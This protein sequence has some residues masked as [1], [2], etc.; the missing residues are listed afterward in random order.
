MGGV[1]R[2]GR[3]TRRKCH[4]HLT[5]HKGE[6]LCLRTPNDPPSQL[7]FQ[8]L[9]ALGRDARPTITCSPLSPLSPLPTP[10]PSLRQAT[11]ALT[12]CASPT[13]TSCEFC[14]CSALGS[15]ETV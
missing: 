9:V 6:G 7:P 10:Y 13:W 12:K 1:K 2:A 4:P 14:I 5:S 11:H 15:H 3:P 8:I